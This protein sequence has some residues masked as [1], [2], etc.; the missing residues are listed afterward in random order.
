MVVENYRLVA[1]FSDKQVLFF[2]LLLKGQRSFQLHTS[3]LERGTRFR[4]TVLGG[5]QPLA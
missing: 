4:C 2:N 5:L 1:Q 3:Q